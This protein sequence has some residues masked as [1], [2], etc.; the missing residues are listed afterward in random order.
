MAA[1]LGK[2]GMVA[3]RVGIETTGAK[4]IASCADH[5]GEGRAA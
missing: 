5:H 4:P 2:V 1:G 3:R